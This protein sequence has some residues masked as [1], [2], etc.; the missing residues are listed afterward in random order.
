MK[1]GLALV[2]RELNG[3][4][5]SVLR[6]LPEPRL[7]KDVIVKRQE[8]ALELV[9]DGFLRTCLMAVRSKGVL[10]DFLA[11]FCDDAGGV[12]DRLLAAREL[13]QGTSVGGWRAPAV[14]DAGADVGRRGFPVGDSTC[15]EL[16]L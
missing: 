15:A 3:G 5:A 10:C 11:A 16:R 14:A 7:D 13:W 9:L 12:V 6:F 1:I 4:V 8:Q 2:L